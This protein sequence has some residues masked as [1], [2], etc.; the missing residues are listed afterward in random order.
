MTHG[1]GKLQEILSHQ[2]KKKKSMID[3]KLENLTF[4]CMLVRELTFHY[5]HHVLDFQRQAM[6]QIFYPFAL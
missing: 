6:N 1:H 4:H 5:S 2:K 3:S